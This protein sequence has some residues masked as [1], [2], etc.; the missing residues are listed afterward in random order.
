MIC[1]SFFFILSNKTRADVALADFADLAA[2]VVLPRSH[3]DEMMLF[4]ASAALKAFHQQHN[5]REDLMGESQKQLPSPHC[6]T[7]ADV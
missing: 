3:P 6:N 4:C 2:D 7:P 5:M 1:V